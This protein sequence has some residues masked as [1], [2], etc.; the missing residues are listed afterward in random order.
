ML[1]SNS[2]VKSLGIHVVS[3]EEETSYSILQQFFY[4]CPTMS[5]TL[6]SLHVNKYSN[7]AVFEDLENRNVS[8]DGWNYFRGHSVKMSLVMDITVP[9]IGH[10]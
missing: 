2:K 10:I 7:S 5:P 9:L 6:F 4:Q 8:G 3:P 1:R